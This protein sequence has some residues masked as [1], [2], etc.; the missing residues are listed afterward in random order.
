[1]DCP[2]CGA[3]GSLLYQGLK[4]RFS[5]DGEFNI[6]RCGNCGLL[7]LEAIPAQD[8]LE[9]SYECFYE[10]PDMAVTGAVSGKRPLA[11][12]RDSLREGIICGYFGYRS[13]HANHPLCW[14]AR[15]LGA[16][17]LLRSR[18]I[19]GLSELFPPSRY[20]AQGL[21]IDVG[22]GKGD[23][24]KMMQQLGWKVTGVE[25]YPEAAR[26]AAQKGITVIDRP[27]ERSGLEDS[28]ADQI[29]MIHVIEHVIDPVL[30]IKECFRILKERGRLVIHTPN[31]D[32]LGHKIFKQYWY[33]L[34]PPRHLRIYSSRSMRALFKGSP[35]SKICV[36][37]LTS[38]SRTT[39][40][41]SALIARS[42]TG[43]NKRITPQRGR[44]AFA[45]LE[46]LLC[47]SGIP[48]AEEIEVVATK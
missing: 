10:E 3:A 23:Y 2:L 16:L 9:K 37:A 25:P 27:F 14:L 18:A 12:L 11:I 35:F 33:S 43:W 40:D 34:D 31:A 32:S 20:N 44:A 38:H 4:D 39:Y 46:L 26:I 28:I 41:N 1:M 5:G 19:Y 8:V 42:A 17:P 47:H 6:R 13:I 48:C 45:F 29:S 15:V 22:C 30:T 7:W 21:L 24:L 36:R